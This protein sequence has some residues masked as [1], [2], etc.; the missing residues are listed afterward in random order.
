VFGAERGEVLPIVV[1]T[2]GAM[3]KNTIRALRKLGITSA[4]HL[5]T[6]FLMALQS[7]IEIYHAFIDYDGALL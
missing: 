4:G 3:P 1:G 2:R 5:R 7:S 6:I